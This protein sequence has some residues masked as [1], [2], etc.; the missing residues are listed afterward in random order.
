MRSGKANANSIC[1]LTLLLFACVMSASAGWDTRPLNTL[2]SFKDVFFLNEDRGWIVGAN[3]AIFSTLDGGK[4]WAHRDHFTSDDLVQ[5]YFTDAENGWL[6][7][8]RSI[9]MGGNYPVSYLRRTTDGGQTWEQVEFERAGRERVTHILFS[10]G[11]S[12]RA[13]G[14]G[15]IFYTL[16]PDKKTWKKSNSAV[17]FVLLNGAFSDD[18]TGAIVG[19]GGTIIFTEDGGQT[20][21]RATM[22]GDQQTRFNAVYFADS[23]AGA[24]AV[25]SRGKIFH[26]KGGAR[27]WRQQ[28]SVVTADLNDVTFTSPLDGWA[29]GE[30]G[31][32]LRTRDGGLSWTDEKSPVDHSLQRIISIN[33]RLWAVGFG[34]TVLVYDPHRSDTPGYRPQL[35]SRG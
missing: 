34:G 20:W 30:S 31:I 17:H 25:G 6:L 15:G 27:L 24:W 16:Q 7:C 1:A 13:F 35:K 14:E 23:K 8:Q 9:Y 28:P 12:A 3:G 26:S 4:M 22:L 18:R 10:K 11:G 33:A 2:A 32:I 29:V 21:D 5:I 19:S